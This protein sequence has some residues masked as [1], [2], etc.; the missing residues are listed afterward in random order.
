MPLNVSMEITC[1][2]KVLISV[3]P[4]NG[5]LHVIYRKRKSRE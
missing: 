3:S 4:K 1:R 5:K 2:K